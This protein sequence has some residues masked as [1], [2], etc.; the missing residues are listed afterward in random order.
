MYRVT[1]TDEEI[2]DLLN[3]VD[4][5]IDEGGSRFSGMSYEQ[6]ISEALRWLLGQS[7]DHPYND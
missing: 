2:N 6:G 1:R 7:D 5:R 4:E 3:A